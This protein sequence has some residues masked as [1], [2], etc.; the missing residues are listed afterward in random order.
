L[1]DEPGAADGGLVDR[2]LLIVHPWLAGGSGE[3]TYPRDGAIRPLSLH[4]G[5]VT[6]EG[7]VLL[8][9]RVG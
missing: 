2:L 9:C 7:A 6:V 3:G 8:D 4:A 1:G 5:S